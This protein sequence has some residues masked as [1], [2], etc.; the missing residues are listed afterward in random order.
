MFMP[1][2]LGESTVWIHSSFSDA[3]F[4]GKGEY[5]HVG[6]SLFI[7]IQQYIDT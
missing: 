7:D 6:G 5:D 3:H 4:G 2:P 1:L